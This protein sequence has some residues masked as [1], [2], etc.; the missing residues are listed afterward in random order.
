MECAEAPHIWAYKGHSRIH[1]SRRVAGCSLA[2]VSS[3]PH[4]A[5]ELVA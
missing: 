1:V 3:A 5:V 2:R 4:L